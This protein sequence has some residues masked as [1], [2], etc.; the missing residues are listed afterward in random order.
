MAGE[1]DGRVAL[2][3]GAASGIGAACA[4]GFAR[5]GARVAVWDIDSA[6]GDRVAQ[7]IRQECGEASAWAST[8]DVSDQTATGAALAELVDTYGAVHHLVNSA[9]SFIA[10][11]SGATRAQWD[12]ALAVNVTGPAMLTASVS[13]HMPPGRPWSTSRASPPMLPSPTGGP[14]TPARRR[15]S[16]S[17]E[18]RRWTSATSASG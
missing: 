3:T 1:L 15:S 13:A 12:Q 7:Q 10:A 11:G 6:G 9:V 17:P 5:A 2:V 14:T 8:V 4:L 18:G 16:R